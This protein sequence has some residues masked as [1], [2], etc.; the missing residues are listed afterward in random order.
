MADENQDRPAK[1]ELAKLTEQVTASF[2]RTPSPRT[3]QVLV[4][5]V[6]HLHAFAQD[7]ALTKEE[8]STAIDFL[9]RTGQACTLTRQEFILLSDVLGL[10]MLTEI[11]AEDGAVGDAT[12][13]TVLGPFHM[14]QSPVRQLGTSTEVASEA[15]QILVYGQVRSSTGTPLAGAAADIWQADDDGFYDVQQPEQ[16]PPGSGRGLFTCD[17]DGWFYFRT[18]PPA[19]YPIPTDGPVGELLAA[20]QRHPYRPAHIHLLVTA[21]QHDSL[22]T[23]IF[24]GGSP[25][26]NSDA[27]FA[28]RPSLIRA[29]TTSNDTD[30]LRCFPDA[31]AGSTSLRIDVVLR[32]AE[33]AVD[34][35]T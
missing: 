34:V 28:V 14:T 3:R 20:S 23:H 29:P 27:V 4:A 5:L 15:A 17:E 31:A 30:L 1:A 21:P 7:V 26:L 13:A 8:W 19:P 2:Q 25:Y 16:V 24:L 11:I 22:T 6:R 10:S 33:N 35:A 18:V 9:T 12:E 32:A